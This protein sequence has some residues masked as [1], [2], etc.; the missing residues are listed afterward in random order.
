MSTATAAAL[1]PVNRPGLNGRI[2]NPYS[3]SGQVKTTLNTTPANIY[4][5]L[6]KRTSTVKPAEL[7]AAIA[8]LKAKL[9][10]SVFTQADFGELRLVDLKDL[11]VNI[12]NQRDIDW[13]H[14]FYILR[15]FDPRIVQVINVIELPD[16]RLS[17]PE[18]QHTAV[19]LF[20]LYHSNLV[21]RDFKVMVKVIDHALAV[22]GSILTGEAFGNLLFRV[23]NHKGRKEIAAYY[24]FRSRVNGVRLYGS[25]LQEDVH[26][27]Q[28]QQALDR[29]NMFASPAHFAR[30][31]G[32]T[33]GMV[34]YISGLIDISEHDTAGFAGGIKDLDWCLRMH[35]Q[36][37]Y[38]E[39]GVDGGFI[40]ALGR[41][42]KLAREQNIVIDKQYE[43]DFMDFFR[44]RY[45]SPKMFHDECKTRLRK[46]QRANTLPETWTDSCLR[47]VL[48]MDFDQWCKTKNK[49][50]PVLNDLNTK[51]FFGM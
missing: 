10:G 20:I 40:L 51:K 12:D 22:P 13:P 39:K 42:A 14:I 6:K 32:A 49:S 19:V 33:P 4:E 31:N 50:Y 18:G 37:F 36:Y 45:G 9:N 26:A 25:T 21:P 16:G 48:I 43:Q 35:D 29:N 28:I 8:D 1:P 38:R 46:F 30:G 17:I 41:Y 27:E 44:G 11:F 15:N 23:I 24:L 7:S 47:P 5:D 3:R 2:M 34:T